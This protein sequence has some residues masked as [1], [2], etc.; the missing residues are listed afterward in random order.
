MFD[1]SPQSRWNADARQ[2]RNNASV[3][4]PPVE[5]ADKG[6]RKACDESLLVFLERIFPDV[7]PLGWSNSHISI[8]EDI[9]DKIVNGGLKAIGMPRGSGKTSIVL[10]AALWAILTRH[11]RFCCLVA[12]DE[13][14]AIAGLNTIKTEINFNPMLGDIYGYETWCIRQLGGEGRRATAQHWDGASTGVDYDQKGICFGSIPGCLTSG[15]RIST[16]GITGRIRGQQSTTLSGE[17]IRP[18]FVICDDPQTKLSAASPSQCLKRHETMQGDVLGLAGPGI[19]ISGFA[20]CTVIYQNDLA[21]RL[22][23]NNLSPD[24]NGS[25]I[26]MILKWPKN[27]QLWDEYNTIRLKDPDASVQFVQNHYDALHEGAE[28]YWE[29]RKGADDASALHHAMDLY[30]R[31]PGVFASEYQNNPLAIVDTAPYEINVDSLMRR[32]VGIPRGRVPND[33]D[34]ITAFIDVQRE[35]LYYTVVAWGESGRGYIVDYGSC[36]DQQRVHWT[37]A[38]VAYPLSEIYGDDFETFLRSG[39]DWLITAILENEYITEDGGHVQVDRLAIDSR[40]GESTHVIR[41]LCREHKHRSRIHPSMGVFIGANSKSWQKLS[42]DKKDKKG[43]HSKL[44]TPKEAGRRELL[45]DTNYWKSWVADRLTC[46]QSSPKAIVLFDA[47]PHEHRMFAEHCAW[48]TPLR[49]IGKA[50][51]E[52]VEWKQ[53]NLG[54]TVEND[55]WDCLVGNAAL[56]STIGVET[57]VGNRKRVAGGGASL[58]RAIERRQQTGNYPLFKSR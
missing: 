41:K 32:V 4:A 2:R 37:K 49:V 21:D 8:I 28:V 12:A 34:K 29:D 46:N 56:A 10:R 11:R 15:A 36:P 39:L 24:W 1:E 44:Q 33:V 54:G 20:T 45:Y 19:K 53:K 25:K 30:Y 14:S 18:D 27:M 3:G 47:Q 22:L 50:N 57:H 23:D 48:E 42:G 16:A 40:W 5:P 13:Y 26:S 9:Q 55:Y 6:L 43:V 35:L 31:D 51:N 7:F 17:V 38:T 58:R 52:V